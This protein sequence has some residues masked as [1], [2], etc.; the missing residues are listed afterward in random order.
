[1]TGILHFLWVPSISPHAEQPAR[2]HIIELKP[3]KILGL[4]E[5]YHVVLCLKYGIPFIVLA[6][7][8]LRAGSV[9]MSFEE[10]TMKVIS[11]RELLIAFSLHVTGTNILSVG[12]LEFF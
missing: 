11:L 9:F 5:I 6:P 4:D 10:R 3:N 7:P 1:V 8:S 12:F 2:H